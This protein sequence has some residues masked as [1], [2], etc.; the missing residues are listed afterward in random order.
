MSI[1]ADNKNLKSFLD[2]KV[3]QYNHP[4][5]IKDDPVSIPHSFTKKQDIEI[6]G[7]FAALLAWGNRRSIINSCTT[8]FNLMDNAPHQFIQQF[9]EKDLV[10]FT[11]FV[12]RTFNKLDLFHLL[13][14]LKY[15]YL[16]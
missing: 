14:F 2:S 3:E 8:L 12:H 1:N 16:I 7:L 9:A 15:H 10:A 4:S 13:N 6:A 5:F 11:G